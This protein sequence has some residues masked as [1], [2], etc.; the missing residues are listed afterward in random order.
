MTLQLVDYVNIAQILIASLLT[1]VL[2]LQAKGAGISSTLG[3]GSGGSFRT[4][5]GIEK[6]LFQ[7]TILLAIVFLVVSIVG[8]RAAIGN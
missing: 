8:V 6:T 2:L 1:L 7:V 4:R 5:R 3:G